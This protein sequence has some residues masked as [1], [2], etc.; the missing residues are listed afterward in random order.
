MTERYT[1]IDGREWVHPPHYGIYSPRAGNPT[2]VLDDKNAAETV[3]E[4]LNKHIVPDWLGGYYVQEIKGIEI[5][6]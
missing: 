2:I 1:D 4:L 6:K 5:V 3:A